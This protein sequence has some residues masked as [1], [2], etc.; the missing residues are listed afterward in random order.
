[1]KRVLVDQGSGAK[2]MYPNLYKRL[3]LKPKDLTAY[4][5]LLV[6]FDGKVVIP[7]G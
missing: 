7:R 2:I 1:M 6:S 3:N 5:S 4:N